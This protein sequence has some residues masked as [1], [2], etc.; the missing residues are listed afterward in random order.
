MKLFIW[1]PQGYGDS[2]IVVLAPDLD[3]AV[4]K[5][6]YYGDQMNRLPDE[7]VEPSAA[8]EPLIWSETRA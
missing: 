1:E 5:A 7:I 8:T 3:A 6:G 2:L 4:E